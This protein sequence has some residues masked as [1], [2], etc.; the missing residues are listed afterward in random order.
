MDIDTAEIIIM[1]NQKITHLIQEAR[2][3]HRQNKLEDAISCINIALEEDVNIAELYRIRAIIYSGGHQW[4]NAIKSYQSALSID[5]QLESCWQGMIAAWQMQGNYSE[6]LNVCDQALLEC[7]TAEMYFNKGCLLMQLGHFEKACECFLSVLKLN[8][9]FTDAWCNL[10]ASQVTF[11]KHELAEKY[12]LKALSIQP[13][14]ESAL[15]GLCGLYNLMGEFEKSLKYLEGNTELEYLSP[16]LTLVYCE[17]LFL[18]GN[19][20]S[21]YEHLKQLIK[22]IHHL[23]G[24]LASQV[25]YQAAKYCDKLQKF[26]EAIEYA[27]KANHYN[28]LTYNDN[29]ISNRFNR[30]RK[31]I[32]NQSEQKVSQ[33]KI[34]FIV[35]LPRSGTSLCEQIFA[36]HPDIHPLGEYKGL[37]LCVEELLKEDNSSVENSL[38]EHY[39]KDLPQPDDNSGILTDKMWM[40]FESLGV[41]EK[42]FPLAKIIHCTRD[43]RDIALSCYFQ[44]FAGVG[45]TFTY[46]KDHFCLYYKQY[47]QQMKYWKSHCKLPLLEWNYEALIQGDEQDRALMIRS[48]IEYAEID[49]NENCLNFYTN[50]RV[51]TTASVHQ[52]NKKIYKNSNQRFKNYQPW[53]VDWFDALQKIQNE[54]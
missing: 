40:N 51:V 2:E 12:F 46:N 28:L 11:S 35:G 42:L 16:P 39:T 20:I 48:L 21:A 50:Q 45:P 22:S 1:Y 31:Y 41:I 52:V 49:W 43:I 4:G 47:L 8:P 38:V 10:A 23:P 32:L 14:H 18:K 3:N 36:S 54:N 26:A 37:P 6:A 30:I 34:I 33:R 29:Q 19:E 24:D 5:P 17:S 9:T 7:P 27:G 25:F 13:N 15:S 44:S 53:L